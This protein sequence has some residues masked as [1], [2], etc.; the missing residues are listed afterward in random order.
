M[1]INW[2]KELQDLVESSRSKEDRVATEAFA[3]A[4]GPYFE[5]PAM[6]RTLLG[7]IKAEIDVQ[8]VKIMVERHIT[9]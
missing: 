3:K 6:L 7:K 1:S 4:I 8:P 5:N 9:L 2:Q